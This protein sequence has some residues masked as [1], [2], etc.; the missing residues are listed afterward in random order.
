MSKEGEREREK[1]R[2][3][4]ERERERDFFVLLNTLSSVP[5]CEFGMCGCLCVCV[6]VCV[7]LGM[8]VGCMYV[9]RD[10]RAML[11]FVQSLCT[12]V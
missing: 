1:E 8:C 6:C 5:V 4:R 3:R 9:C 7:C 10:I 11:V 12:F 2:E